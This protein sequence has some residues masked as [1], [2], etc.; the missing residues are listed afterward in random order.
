MDLCLEDISEMILR[1]TMNRFLCRITCTSWIPRLRTSGS[2]IGW[3]MGFELILLV[4]MVR[5][6]PIGSPL[7][8]SITMLLGFLAHGKDIW[9]DF[10]LAN[11]LA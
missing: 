1:I 5:V 10:H 9:L 4:G 7:V 3:D 8:Y 6:A 2:D 11:W